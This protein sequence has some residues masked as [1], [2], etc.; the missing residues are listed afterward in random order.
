MNKDKTTIFFSKNTRKETHEQYDLP[1]IIGVQAVHCYENYLGLLVMVGRE[2]NSLL[3]NIF[4][5]EYGRG[6]VI[7][8]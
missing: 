5:I 6:L 7:G 2:V 1:G 3:L 4:W 8:N